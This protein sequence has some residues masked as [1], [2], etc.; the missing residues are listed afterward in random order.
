MTQKIVLVHVKQPQYPFLTK[1]PS[2]HNYL[3]FFQFKVGILKFKSKALIKSFNFAS[4][5]YVS[6]SP[7]TEI[8]SIAYFH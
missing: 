7:S 4:I 8:A 5:A 6:V 2:V 3:H 1:I